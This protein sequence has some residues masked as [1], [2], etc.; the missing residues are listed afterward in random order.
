LFHEAC[1]NQRVKI[2]ALSREAFVGAPGMGIDVEV[3]VLS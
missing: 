2:L 1:D 3:E